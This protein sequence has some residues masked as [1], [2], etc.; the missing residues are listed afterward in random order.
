[1]QNAALSPT[2]PSVDEM[3]ERLEDF[4]SR[5]L[6]ALHGIPAEALPTS[7]VATLDRLATTELR[8]LLELKESF[9]SAPRP[10]SAARALDEAAADLRIARERTL[11]LLDELQMSSQLCRNLVRR[12]Y[13]E[14]E[15]Q[16]A[17]IEESRERS[18]LAVTTTA[19]VSR[20]VASH[21]SSSPSR[22]YSDGITIRD[23]WGY[24]PRRALL[25]EFAPGAHWPGLDHHV[26]GPEEVFVL[27]GEFD[28]GAHVYPA[29]SFLHHPAGSSHSPTTKSGCT[30]L[31]F[32]PEG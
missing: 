23:L 18:G 31:V 13:E 1:M 3:L 19:D 30:L 9:V 25:V 15:R 5:L 12:L 20:V 27:S 29:G 24:G 10:C 6:L 7:I 22:S 28:D 17:T 21:V 11:R 2:S 26:P 16:L 8:T 4:P 32:Y 14:Q